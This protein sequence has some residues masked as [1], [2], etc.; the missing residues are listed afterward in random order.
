MHQVEQTADPQTEAAIKLV[1]WVSRGAIMPRSDDF[2]HAPALPLGPATAG[3]G[4]ILMVARRGH[5]ALNVSSEYYNT[6]NNLTW[7]QSC[8]RLTLCA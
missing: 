5:E 2:Q 8:K 6:I 4:I 1:A 3:G 7:R